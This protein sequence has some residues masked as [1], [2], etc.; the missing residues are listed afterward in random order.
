LYTI[1]MQLTRSQIIIIGS[2][3]FIAF[4]FIGVLTGIIPGTRR[5]L[6][7]PPEINLTVWGTDSRGIMSDNILA[8]EAFRTNVKISYEEISASTYERDVIN[9]LAAGR[10]PDI[11]MFHNTWLPK[12]FDKIIPVDSSQ[13]DF[14][15]LQDLFPTVVEQDFASGETIYALPLYIDT[16][17]L[18]YNQD[19][20]NRAGIAVPPRDWLDFQN[21]IPKLIQKD[22][23]G[24]LVRPAA[25]IGGSNDSIDNASD[26]LMLL[27]LQAGARMT[28]DDFTQASFSRTV[29]N[30]SPGVD[31]L[32]F[33]TKFTDPRDEFYTWDENFGYSLDSFIKG[34]TSMIFG[35][36]EQR[37]DI[38]N[39]N[40]FLNFRAGEMPQPTGSERSVNYPNYWGLAVANSSQN[41]EWAWDF[42]LYLT[43]NE[44]A[45]ETYLQLANRP[46][47]LRSLIQ[48]YTNHPELGIY[49]K[50]ALSARSW[51]QID[52][53]R[54]ASIFSDMIKAVI[55][56]QLDFVTAINQGE[57]QVTELMGVA[58]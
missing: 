28:N 17:V 20:F 23:F 11:I 49:A 12:H 5:N 45:A 51:P 14:K 36:G 15:S 30:I 26:I 46:P 4:L 38:Q 21:L 54:I 16:L 57:R 19:S 10:A 25:A 43:A 42:I 7:R 48:R 6:E 55:N 32:A 27:M 33:Y 39:R 1:S 50:Q 44:S 35:Y 22:Q 34:D 3:L 53:A 52:S 29:N 40:P 41:P 37:K 2:V 31:A 9:A 47:A 56:N 8:Y 24:N 18:F 13:F 58:R